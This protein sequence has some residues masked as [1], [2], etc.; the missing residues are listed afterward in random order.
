LVGLI[1]GAN[2]AFFPRRF[3]AVA[4]ERVLEAMVDAFTTNRA[5]LL[6]ASLPDFSPQRLS[7]SVYAIPQGFATD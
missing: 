3:D 1:T 4:F 7:P 6:L 2:D 5:T